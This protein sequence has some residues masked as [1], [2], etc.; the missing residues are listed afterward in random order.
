VQ[1]I[2]SKKDSVKKRVGVLRGGTGEHYHSSLRKGG[3]IISH[4]SE[5]LA[6]KYKT[7]DILIDKEGV[8]HLNGIPISPADLIHKVDLVWDTTHPSAGIILDNF[9]IPNIGSGS[10]LGNN[11]DLIRKHVKSIGLNMPRQIVSP[12]T[13]RAVFEKFGAPWIVGDELVKTFAELIELIENNEN[14]LVEEFI[15]GKVASVHS[16]P[17]FRGQDF[18]TFPVVNVFGILSGEE[19]EK[20]TNLTK[21]LHKHIGGE[22]YLKSNFVLNKRGKIYLLELDSTPNLKSYSHFAQAC[23]S[24][25]AKMHQVVEHILEKAL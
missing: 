23:E 3:D 4:I 10:F 17:H 12:K 21:D 13:A 5:N 15:A 1:E 24:V 6:D 25:G 9:S 18:Y 2:K 11:V 20:L 7:I 14:I 8:W 19:K 22:H 16:L